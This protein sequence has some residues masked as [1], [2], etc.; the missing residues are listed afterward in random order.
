[1]MQQHK[2]SR[3]VQIM[4]FELFIVSGCI[5]YLLFNGESHSQLSLKLKKLEQKVMFKF[6]LRSTIS[7]TQIDA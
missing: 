5:V 6:T 2:M 1:M 4:D 3:M 7:K